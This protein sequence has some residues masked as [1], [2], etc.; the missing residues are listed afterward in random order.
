[1]PNFGKKCP[2]QELSLSRNRLQ[3]TDDKDALDFLLECSHLKRLFLGFNK[4]EHL[5]E[6][7][8]NLK[9]HQYSTLYASDKKSKWFLWMF[10]VDVYQRGKVWRSLSFAA[11]EYAIY[12]LKYPQWE[13]FG[14]FVFTPIG[15]R[16]CLLWT[17]CRLWKWLTYRITC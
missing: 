7:W 10:N 2:I 8:L 13:I 1:M 9:I 6:R 11:I 14:S 16:R 3:D 12:H 5:S 17:K 15:W 4:I